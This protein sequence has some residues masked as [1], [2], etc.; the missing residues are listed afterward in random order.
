MVVVVV[1]WRSDGSKRWHGL[2]ISGVDVN[3]VSVGDFNRHR[4]TN[5]KWCD[6]R[7][8]HVNSGAL[9]CCHSQHVW[10]PLSAE[11]KLPIR[12]MS[13]LDDIQPVADLED[14]VGGDRARQH[15]RMAG[16]LHQK[17]WHF[18]GLTLR[19][20]SSVHW[21]PHRWYNGE[22]FRFSEREGRRQNAGLQ[23][24]LRGPAYFPPRASHP[25]KYP[26]G[27]SVNPWPLQPL[28]DE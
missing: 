7:E 8:E 16:Y 15:P 26:R 21:S 4:S 6:T 12:T 17:L 25:K 13:A 18:A 24:G 9:L 22:T 2:L 28:S 14:T 10:S 27:L 19:G 11:K 3:N 23:H 1:M 5:Q 20:Y